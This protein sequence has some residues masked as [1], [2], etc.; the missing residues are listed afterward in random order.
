VQLQVL[1]S[2][3]STI[4]NF[5]SDID[6]ISNQTQSAESVDDSLAPTD[7]GSS[8]TR[9]GKRKALAI[10]PPQKKPRKAVSKT[11]S[12]IKINDLAPI[13]CSNSSE[14]HPGKYHRAPI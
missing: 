14:K 9:A 12:R 8:R 3:F 1:D 2:F 4:P 11:A 5:K 6:P 13:P 10:P 7:I